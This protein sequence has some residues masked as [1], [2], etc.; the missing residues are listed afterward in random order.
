MRDIGIWGWATSRNVTAKCAPPLLF[1]DFV[2]NPQLPSL[3]LHFSRKRLRLIN[4]I[5]VVDLVTI[6]R[7]RFFPIASSLVPRRFSSSVMVSQV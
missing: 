7:K 4:H 1:V 2:F 3:C 5:R 6:S